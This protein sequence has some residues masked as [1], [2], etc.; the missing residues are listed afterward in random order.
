MVG[1]GIAM[2]TSPRV[3]VGVCIFKNGKILLGQRQKSSGRGVYSWCPPGGKLEFGESIEECA[4]RETLEE[5]GIKISD[6]TI[7]TCTNDIFKT[8]HEHFITIYVRANWINGEPQILEPHKMAQ[9]AWFDWDQ[10][11]KPLFMPFSNLLKT[12]FKP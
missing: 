10:L 3:G 4:R 12:G 11:P 1:Q 6:P 5:A 7:I 2:G 9:W 8:E